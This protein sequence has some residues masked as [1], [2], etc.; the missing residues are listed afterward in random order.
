LRDFFYN[1]IN[2]I[3]NSIFLLYDNLVVKF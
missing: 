1:G 3:D 2:L